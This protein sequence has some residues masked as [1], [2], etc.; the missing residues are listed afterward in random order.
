[1]IFCIVFAAP[2]WGMEVKVHIIPK[3]LLLYLVKTVIY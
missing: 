2:V 3:N 1:M